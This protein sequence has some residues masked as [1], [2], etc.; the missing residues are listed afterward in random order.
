MF[1]RIMGDMLH[2]ASLLIL[3]FRIRKTKSCVG[4]SCK[5]QEL[6]FIV[7]VA[8]YLDLF[9]YYV[10]AYNTLMKITFICLT[11][12]LIYLMRFAKIYKQTY[13]SRGDNFEYWKYLL[14]P[15][16]ILGLFFNTEFTHMEILWSFS[17]FLEAVAFI[18]QLEMLRKMREVENLQSHY[19]F[20]LGAYR[21]LYI[22]NWI[23]RFLNNEEISY[24]SLFAG[25]IQSILY[26]DFFY[27][28]VLA[29][30]NNKKSVTLPI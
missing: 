16:F 26:A 4:I 9:T 20:C 7:F 2:V 3:A 1:F 23:S 29:K 11:G 10:S 28:Y 30:L 6:Y 5:T 25:I 19:V 14:G 18:P 13:D 15:C 24:I 21:V 17:I 8:R 22:I 12:Y 27:Y